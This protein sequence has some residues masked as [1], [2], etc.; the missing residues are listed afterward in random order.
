MSEEFRVLTDREHSILRV[1]VYLGSATVEPITGI[2]NY[3]KQTKNVVPALIK[4]V[5]EGCQNSI[6]EHIR[7][8]A[9]FAQNI[10]I[11]I[12]QTLDG[13]EIVV[14]DDGRGI[15]IQ[16][17]G[18]SYR[19]LLAWT[20]LRAGS[21]FDDSKRVGVGANGMGVSLT[22]IFSKS[23]IGRTC[24]GTGT[25]TVT[26]SDNMINIDS[27]LSKSI[28]PI[29]ISIFYVTVLRILR[30]CTRRSILHFVAKS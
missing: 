1:N 22:N 25:F 6:D 24:D 26:C 28:T 19:P 30:Y 16:K 3:T 12:N 21:N 9:K 11:D 17:I 4:M 15:P 20:E 7:T 2:I 18:D 8:N 13:T 27:K 23:F 14:T 29:G 10:S 5:E